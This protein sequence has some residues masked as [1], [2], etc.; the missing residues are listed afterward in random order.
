VPQP[1]TLPHAP[2]L[3]YDVLETHAVLYLFQIWMHFST[4]LNPTDI[5]LKQPSSKTFWG[6]VIR[7]EGTGYNPD[8]LGSTLCKGKR[9]FFH[10]SIQTATGTHPA[11]YPMRT[12]GSF[13]GVKR[14][15]RETDDWSPTSA[16]VK[17]C[18]AILPL[19]PNVFTEDFTILHYNL[20]RQTIRK[21]SSMCLK[22]SP[23][24][25]FWCQSYVQNRI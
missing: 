3:S 10:H 1:T 4:L 8:H 22:R 7:W 20:C 17:N 14:P 18:G 12:S 6:Y 16:E 9:I 23:V 15:G 2:K 24:C 19:P 11:S 5:K 21:K 25:R 13:P